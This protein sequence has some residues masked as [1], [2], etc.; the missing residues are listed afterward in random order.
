MLGNATY[1]GRSVLLGEEHDGDHEPLVSAELWQRVAKTKAATARTK[2]K[3]RGRPS[4]GSHLFTRGLRLTCAH[5]G[6]AMTPRSREPYEVYECHG[7]LKFGKA[8]CPMTPVPRAPIDSAVFA[9]FEQ[10]GLDLDAMRAEL[11]AAAE[12]KAL[13][14]AELLHAAERGER[15][16]A[17]AVARVRRDYTSG[18]ITAAEW[19]DLSSDLNGDHEAAQAKLAQ[20]RTRAAEVEA[21]Q[22]AAGDAEGEAVRRLADVRAAVPGEVNNAGDL[23]AVRAALSRMFVSFTIARPEVG[24]L[25][26]FSPVERTLVEAQEVDID[27]ALAS[28]GATT[29]AVDRW[30]IIPWAREEVVSG[31]DETWRPILDREPLTLSQTM[32]PSAWP[33]CWLSPSARPYRFRSKDCA[34]VR[35]VR[36]AS[37]TSRWTPTSRR[38]APETGGGPTAAT[39]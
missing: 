2:G 33:R 20:F 32:M 7:R 16:A 6:E 14:V 21:A 39:A 36:G 19:R 34:R 15:K 35:H 9:Y 29:L 26:D 23:D 5:C 11:S 31:V 8:S 24:D 18:E 30:E 10:V 17:E 4:A 1:A 37:G 13:E 22:S 3:G 27:R 38:S 28:D 12:S 25:A